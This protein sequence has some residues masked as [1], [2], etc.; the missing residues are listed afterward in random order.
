MNLPIFSP[1]FISFWIS[2]SGLQPSDPWDIRGRTKQNKNAKT[3]PEKVNLESFSHYSLGFPSIS[4]ISTSHSGKSLL[5][6]PSSIRLAICR[7][8]SGIFSTAVV[9]A[10]NSILIILSTPS[11]NHIY[12]P[13]YTKTYTM[14]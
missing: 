13:L 9:L 4:L 7:S 1:S 12:S 11:I 14:S 5:K 3:C 10:V 8:N 2:K 6:N